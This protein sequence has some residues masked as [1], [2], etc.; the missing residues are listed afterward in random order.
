MGRQI[1]SFFT[2]THKLPAAAWSRK[3]DLLH[4]HTQSSDDDDDEDELQQQEQIVPGGDVRV[5]A[6][7]AKGDHWQAAARGRELQQNFGLSEEAGVR[8][9]QVHLQRNTKNHTKARHGMGS[10]CVL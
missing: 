10:I 7:R 1:G 6:G 5:E 4:H 3:A 9:E 8:V 2:C